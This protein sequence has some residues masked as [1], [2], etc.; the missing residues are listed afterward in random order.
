MILR[1]LDPNLPALSTVVT[2]FPKKT[3]M[4][5]GFMVV[6]IFVVLYLCE[7]KGPRALP[8][9]EASH[10]IIRIALFESEL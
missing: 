10:L 9:E 5:E 7:F 8:S 3:M 1:A 2:N 6:H 4:G